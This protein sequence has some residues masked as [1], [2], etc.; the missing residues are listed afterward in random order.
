MTKP[1]TRTLLIAAVSSLSAIVAPAAGAADLGSLLTPVALVTG[2]AA[3][4][5][6]RVL[7]QPFAPWGDSA[8]YFPAA[9]GSFEGGAPG[10]SLTGGASVQAGGNPFLS[11]GSSLSLP[12]GSSATSPSICV[13]LGSPTMRAFSNAQS[14]YVAVSV[15]AA[16]LTLPVGVITSRGSWQPTP[17]F[18]MLANT[19]G[20]LTPTGTTNVSF[21]FTAVG[22]AAR[23]DDV[24]VDPYRRT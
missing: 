13:D 17:I 19:L 3:P 20:I 21:R 11:S 23:L 12:A 15:L 24:Y 8:S 1:R 22:G 4:C 10:W 7:S 5:T 16:G 14:G 9:G 6:G 18:I 2:K